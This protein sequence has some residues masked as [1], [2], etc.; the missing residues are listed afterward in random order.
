MADLPQ[1][2]SVTYDPLYSRNPEETIYDY[3]QRL[4]A[5]RASGVLGGG[6]M[7][8]VNAQIP[9]EEKSIHYMPTLGQLVFNNPLLRDG[10]NDIPRAESVPLTEEQRL[11]NAVDVATGRDINLPAVAGV[12]MGPAG[13]IID[14]VATNSRNKIIDDALNSRAYTPE[15][16][17]RILND[18]VLL[19]QM[20][21]EGN[22][23]QKAPEDTNR[24]GVDT[25]NWGT[26]VKDAIDNLIDRVTG[27]NIKPPPVAIGRTW[28]VDPRPQLPTLGNNLAQQE[29]NLQR[30]M[31]MMD[32]LNQLNS[33]TI[34]AGNSGYYT[35]SSG[36]QYTGGAD[37]G[38]WTGVSS[39]GLG[40]DFDSFDGDDTY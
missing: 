14:T 23:S 29:R 30:T 33:G 39:D 7:F 28:A 1:Y 37:Y 38:G 22:L 18:R 19:D 9:V 26:Q 24:F 36:N 10:D 3:M 31:G 20:L 5:Q 35:D 6:G 40:N 4:A 32:T 25:W 11:A 13:K 12:V 16:K 8:D 21:Y 15:Q 34:A 27:D 2:T 17:E